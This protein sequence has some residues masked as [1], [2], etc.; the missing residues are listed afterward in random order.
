MISALSHTARLARAGFV[1]AREGVFALVD[2]A[3]LPPP[4][5]IGLKLARL[6]ERPTSKGAAGRLPAA[7]TKLGP[8][9]VKLGQFLATRPDVVGIALAR[10]LESLQDQMAPF[11]RREAE[12][13]VTAALGKPLGEA[14]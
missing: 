14:F 9:Y 11:P 10:D 5:R 2:P 8:T 4:A 1:L 12:A 6:I 3:A 7:L 13:V